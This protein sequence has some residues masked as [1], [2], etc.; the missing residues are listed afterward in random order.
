MVAGK[1]R[2][3]PGVGAKSVFTAAPRPVFLS[4]GFAFHELNLL[5]VKQPLE[6]FKVEGLCVCVWVW[7][8]ASAHLLTCDVLWLLGTFWLLWALDTTSLQ[9]FLSNR[10]LVWVIDVGGLVTAGA[11]R[12]CMVQGSG[13]G[14]GFAEM[15]GSFWSQK[16]ACKNDEPLFCRP[17]VWQFCITYELSIWEVYM[18]FFFSSFNSHQTWGR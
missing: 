9:V 16:P 5:E 14:Y 15:W 11:N 8:C 6:V 13:R 4:T 1:E 18:Y 12:L 2:V 3:R 17:Q 10:L 7:V